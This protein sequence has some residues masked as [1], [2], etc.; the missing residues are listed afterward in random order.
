MKKRLLIMLLFISTFGCLF[1]GGE[2]SLIIPY[3]FI[4]LGLVNELLQ[5]IIILTYLISIQ[6][7]IFYLLFAKRKIFFIL[8]PLI[9]VVG[10]QL[11][12]FRLGNFSNWEI[13]LYSL[14]PFIIIWV[15]LIIR[16]RK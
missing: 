15:L 1:T 9:Y 3:L 2:K 5:N 6:F 8:I 13:S 7:L 10:F 16:I 14:I 11:L 4:E 12:N